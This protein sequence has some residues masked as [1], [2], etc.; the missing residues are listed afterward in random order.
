[1]DVY[2]QSCV[3][4]QGKEKNTGPDLRCLPAALVLGSPA[5]NTFRCYANL[6]I[7]VFRDMPET[8]M[9]PF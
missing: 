4:V 5:N 6:D 9:M 3:S 2:L 8:E 1:M 7:E